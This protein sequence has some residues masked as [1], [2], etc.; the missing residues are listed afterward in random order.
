MEGY[1]IM[2]QTAAQS[3]FG[4]MGFMPTIWHPTLPERQSKYERHQGQ[5][6]MKRRRSA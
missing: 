4:M 3:L 5:R 6:E 1:Q 2:R